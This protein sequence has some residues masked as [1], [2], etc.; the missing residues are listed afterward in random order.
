M[1]NHVTS[2]IELY[3]DDEE[4]VE[5][6]LEEIEGEETDQ[7]IDFEKILPQPEEVLDSMS[8]EPGT[9][10]RQP[11]DWYDWR[12]KNWGTKWNAYSQSYQDLGYGVRELT[13]QTAWAAPRPVIRALM[14]KYPGLHI[15]GHWVEEGHQSAGVY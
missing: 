5:R 3:S 9:G 14:K 2:I 4:L 8:W 13:F 7:F 15:A 11:M 10:T 6:V 12:V 1:P